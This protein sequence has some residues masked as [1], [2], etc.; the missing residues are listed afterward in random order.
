MLK[1]KEMAEI[2]GNNAKNYLPADV[3]DKEPSVVVTDSRQATKGTLFVCIKGENV[4]GHDFI[5]RAIEQGALAVLASRDVFDGKTPGIPVLWADDVV[6]AL[7]LLGSAYRSRY[8]GLVIGLTGSAG[9]TSVKEVLYGALAAHGKT[10][11]NYL[12]MNSQ[13]GLPVSILNAEL[14]SEYWVMEAGINEA[15]DMDV[16]GIILQPDLSMVLNVGAAHIEG[17]GD[18]GVAYYKTRLLTHTRLGGRALVSADYPDLVCESRKLDLPLR[19]FSTRNSDADYY[20]SYNGPAS[21][22]SGR[23]QVHIKNGEGFEVVA[24]FRGCYGSENVAAI[25]GAAHMA[26]LS[27]KEI[28]AGFAGASLPVQRFAC[29][30]KGAFT[31]IDDSYNANP[32]STSR[33]LDTAQEM[34]EESGGPL[35]LV[36]GEMRELG[37]EAVPSH[38][39]LGKQMAK[40]GAKVILWKGGEVEALKTGLNEGGFS[41]IFKHVNDTAEFAAAISLFS[42]YAVQ[43]ENGRYKGVILFKASRSLKMEHFVAVFKNEYFNKLGE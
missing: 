19:F 10:S 18:K 7:G 3:L 30:T 29:Q 38:I 25:T 24:P 20:A 21:A 8:K 43:G 16:L 15:H 1:L 22:A 40:S 41:G 31:L 5:S 42:D 13:F 9:K 23:Y 39:A 35:F 37:S 2:L 32:L 27:P 6:K 36:M 26:G 34:A 33:M 17:L 4:D 11:K 12:N 14:D 28:T